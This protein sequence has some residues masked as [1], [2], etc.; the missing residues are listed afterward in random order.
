MAAVTRSVYIETAL[1]ILAD[2]GFHGLNIGELCQ[3]LGVTSGSFYHHFG[4]WDDF[5]QALLQHWENEQTNR[6]LEM[7]NLHS[8]ARERIEVLKQLAVVLPHEAEAA[9]RAWSKNRAP[10]ATVQQRVDARR[11]QAL[12][13]IITAVG[14]DPAQARMLAT[15]GTSVLVGLQQLRTPVDLDELHALLDEVHQL[16]L[17][18]A[19]VTQRP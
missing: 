13:E 2:R 11:Q 15:L 7:A 14:A 16:V 18:H 12:Q 8:D 5:V 3:R 17:R 10:V 4:S 19:G 9:I 1:A 6:L